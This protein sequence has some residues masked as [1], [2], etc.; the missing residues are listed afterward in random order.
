MKK[1]A[2]TTG[3]LSIA[4]IGISLL[5]KTLHLPASELL[6]AIGLALFSVVFV[7]TIFKYL[8]DSSK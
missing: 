1:I 4:I 8:Y 5:M 6:T 7:P 3:A 2:F